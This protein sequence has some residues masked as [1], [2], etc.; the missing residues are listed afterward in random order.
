MTKRPLYDEWITIDSI[1]QT[2]PVIHIPV[3]K[4]E[5]IDKRQ[6]IDSILYTNNTDQNCCPI[7]SHVQHSVRQ[8]FQHL[9]HYCGAILH[10]L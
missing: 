10:S 9:I 2:E 6:K 5:N 4:R 8:K 1:T 7:C 3:M